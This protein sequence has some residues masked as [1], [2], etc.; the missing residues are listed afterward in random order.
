MALSSGLDKS[1]HGSVAQAPGPHVP[2]LAGRGRYCSAGILRLDG[3]D[4]TSSFTT[5]VATWYTRY[6]RVLLLH[7]SCAFTSSGHG[8]DYC[9][10]Q[11]GL[12]FGS[13]TG[14]IL[15]THPTPAPPSFHHRASPLIALCSP[16]SPPLPSPSTCLHILVAGSWRRRGRKEDGRWLGGT[17]GRGGAYA[18]AEEHV[19]LATRRRYRCGADIPG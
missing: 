5:T 4:G 10:T 2:L 15:R 6:G 3:R 12:P 19:S 7:S 9:P 17:C 8:S 16:L 14:T 18:D 11:T 13:F 1:S